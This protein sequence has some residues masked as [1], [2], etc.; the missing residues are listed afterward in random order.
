[1][2][3]NRE[4]LCPVRETTTYQQLRFFNENKKENIKRNKKPDM[5]STDS[6]SSSVGASTP[7]SGDIDG[8][9][10]HLASSLSLLSPPVAFHDSDNSPFQAATPASPSPDTPTSSYRRLMEN[11]SIVQQT[12]ATAAESRSVPKD[13]ARRAGRC[14][15]SH[16]P[17][18]H[19]NSRVGLHP[20]SFSP[21]Q[22][23][24]RFMFLHK[25]INDT[26]QRQNHARA[27]SISSTLCNCNT[28]SIPPPPPQSTQSI[29]LCTTPRYSTARSSATQPLSPPHVCMTSPLLLRP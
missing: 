11:L 23:I 17:Q 9:S 25:N 28:S 8:I 13:A 14:A 29:P 15:P 20:Y 6:P 10:S 5:S 1:M 18:Y 2:M 4:S 16:L 22:Y 26:I 19:N 27:L 7:G 24:A 12:F 21:Q 3:R